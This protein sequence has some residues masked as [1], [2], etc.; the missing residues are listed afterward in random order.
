MPSLREA[1]PDVP[2]ELAQWVEGLLAKDPAR[3]PQRVEDG[4]GRLEEIAFAT[5]GP[6]WRRDAPLT[7]SQRDGD[8]D[9]DDGAGTAAAATAPA[10]AA[11]RAA[12]RAQTVPPTAETV[13]EAPARRRRRAWVVTAVAGGLA[14]AAALAVALAGGDGGEERQPR[15]RPPTGPAP[16]FAFAGGRQRE[17]VVGLP[18]WRP[19]EV[20][21]RS[22]A[23]LVLGPSGTARVLAAPTPQAGARFGAATASGDFDRDGFADLAVGAPQAR[24]AGE[25]GRPGSVTIF[26]GSAGGLRA[27]RALVLSAPPNYLPRRP[28]RYGAALAAADLNRDGFADLLVG[29]PGNDPFPVEEHGSGSIQ[30]LPGGPDSLSPSRARTLGRPRGSDAAFGEL[31]AVGDVDR[32]GHLDVLEAAA[33]HSSFC[34]GGPRGPTDCRSMGPG[35]R[36]LAAVDMTGDRRADVVHGV[37]GASDGGTVAGV[38]RVWRGGSRGPRGPLVVRQDG[39]HIPGHAQAGDGFGATLAGGDLDGDGFA[40]LLVGAPPEDRHAGRLTL[41]RGAPPATPC[42]ATGPSSRAS[43]ACPA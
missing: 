39:A 17:S 18:A 14:A 1:A 3:R 25:P 35:A 20:A 26:R 36:A 21:R 12:D 41:V 9:D 6:Y 27:D 2:A 7:E 31:L 32:N 8:K 40:D 11:A 15:T 38:V 4:R 43:P 22:G 19:P 23:V 10:I 13:V 28:Q 34:P 5:L 33:G 37:P 24:A 42:P 16:A 29:A 30:L